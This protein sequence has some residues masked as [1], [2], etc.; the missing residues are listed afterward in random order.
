IVFRE[1]EPPL[2]GLFGMMRG[3]DL[4]GSFRNQTWEEPPLTIRTRD[5]KIHPEYSAVKLAIGF[6]P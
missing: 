1:D 6:P 4:P 5:G 3:E 2:I